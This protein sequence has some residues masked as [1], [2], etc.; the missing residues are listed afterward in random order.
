MFRKKS[1]LM[2]AMTLLVV[3]ALAF[4]G[5]GGGDK[6]KDDD[7]GGGFLQATTD[8][9][10]GTWKLEGSDIC[11]HSVTFTVDAEYEPWERGSYQKGSMTCGILGTEPVTITGEIGDN[12]YIQLLIEQFQHSIDVRAFREISV[13]HNVKVEL[14]GE[15][16]EPGVISVNE[17]MIQENIEGASVY[18]YH[19]VSSEHDDEFLLFRKQ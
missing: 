11:P 19:Y 13:T 12:S 5:S 4:A 3:S 16:T 6:D 7:G 15:L 1:I 14:S 8:D 10:L 2:F 18:N 17:L 9:Y